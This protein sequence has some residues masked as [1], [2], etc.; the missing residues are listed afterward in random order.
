VNVGD[1]IIEAVAI[2]AGG[3]TGPDAVVGEQILDVVPCDDALADV[4]ADVMLKRGLVRAPA[5]QTVPQD[6]VPIEVLASQLP[7][8]PTNTL[9]TPTSLGGD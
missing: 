6:F 1:R 2:Y 7:H 5:L 9:D 4:V 8:F 3:R